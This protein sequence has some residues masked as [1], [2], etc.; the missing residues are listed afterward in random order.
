[1]PA[2]NKPYRV[3]LASVGVVS[4]VEGILAALSTLGLLGSGEFRPTL[5][6]VV[7][8]GM[9]S[10]AAIYLLIFA[11][12]VWSTGLAQRIR[13]YWLQNPL[14]YVIV[15]TMLVI[16]FIGGFAL[17]H[18]EETAL[19][20]LVYYI[21]SLRPQI[22]WI[23]L[24][25]LQGLIILSLSL[26]EMIPARAQ[27]RS[28]P[29]GI[30]IHLV[31]I[32]FVG[33]ALYAWSRQSSPSIV[34]DSGDYLSMM[35]QPLF[36]RAF[37]LGLRPWT[38][39]L[40]YKLLPTDGYAIVALQTFLHI[41][42][43][44]F[45]AWTVARSLERGWLRVMIVAILLFMALTHPISLW[46][47]VILSESIAISLFVLM[48]A[49]AIQ[50]GYGQRAYLFPL[51]LTILL[52]I[53]SRESNTLLA[54]FMAAGLLVAGI[55]WKPRRFYFAAGL[56]FLGMVAFSLASS[57]LAKR[58][59]F[60][61]AN[62][63]VQRVLVDSSALR[64]F[65]KQGMPVN[66]KLKD[67]AGEWAFSDRYAI[68]N[69]PRLRSFFRWLN[70][71]GARD[72]AAYLLSRP[73]KSLGDPLANLD[74]LMQ[75]ADGYGAPTYVPIIPYQLGRL[76]FIPLQPLL[77]FLLTQLLSVTG[78]FVAI[79]VRDPLLGLIS[80]SGALIYP[81]AFLV[82]HGDALEVPRHAAQLYLQVYLSFWLLLAAWCNRLLQTL[83]RP[84][85]PRLEVRQF[86]A[87]F[88]RREK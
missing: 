68:F 1:M 86:I 3:I 77:L 72:Y 22:S 79:R 56:L 87:S 50:V 41:F 14:H 82:W 32:A 54:L 75:P 63:I 48:L 43:W 42:S 33:V 62:I 84:P 74:K 46:N 2:D 66:R 80:V 47:H 69:H 78:I 16:L 29:T 30:A 25:S 58:S 39:A 31:L 60:P 24:L 71:E 52:W 21:A 81:H 57:R 28:K 83:V 13:E 18:T 37:Y 23:A 6:R 53:N 7:V 49:L 38:T 64:Y 27:W 40:F 45:L 51:A 8:A 70:T 17:Y 73:M 65:Q 55:V 36:S 34:P 19:G 9:D 10:L 88:M 11:G 61:L 12:M 20:R 4:A 15:V 76:V 44:G 5:L 67:L 85:S 35:R 26:P 59:N